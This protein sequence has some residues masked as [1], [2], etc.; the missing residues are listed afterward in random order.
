MNQKGGVGKTTTAINLAY[1]LSDK[2]HKVTV[3]D[4]DPQSHLSLG[5]GVNTRMQSG[6]D[7]VFLEQSAIDDHVVDVAENLSLLPAGKRLG[8][9]ENLLKGGSERG[10]VLKRAIDASDV[11]RHSDFCI[12]DC[13]PSA[14]LLGMNAL[15]AATELMI[16]VSSDFLS[17]HGVSRM[18]NVIDYIDESLKKQS[19][20]WF[21]MTR[22]HE[23]RR[24]SREV[25]EKLMEYFESAVLA[26]PV[27]E[28]VALAESPS[29]GQSIFDYQPNGNGAKDYRNLAEDLLNERVMQ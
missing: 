2:G 5:M 19:K 9:I 16:P 26:T 27:R 6:V 29:Y 24:L 17:L 13:P 8:E 1:A 28:S 18:I 22:Y 23:R 10:W 12:I 21:V 11:C 3:I 15:F 7:D 25:K 20:R 14:G 4:T